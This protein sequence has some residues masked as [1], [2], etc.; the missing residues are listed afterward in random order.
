MIY[1]AKQNRIKPD[2]GLNFCKRFQRSAQYL[3]GMK[4]HPTALHTLWCKLKTIYWFCYF[5]LLFNLCWCFSFTSWIFNWLKLNQFREWNIFCLALPSYFWLSKN[6]VYVRPYFALITTC[7]PL[8]RQR[9]LVFI[10][11]KVWGGV[12]L[13]KAL[14]FLRNLIRIQLEAWKDLLDRAFHCNRSL[15][16]DSTVR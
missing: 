4:G 11:A 10:V 8:R 2:H 3:M 13:K 12:L 5:R 7:L 15:P 1:A 6:A 14:V 16:T 9:E